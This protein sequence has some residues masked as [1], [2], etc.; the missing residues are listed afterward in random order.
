[1]FRPDDSL[2]VGDLIDFTIRPPS[3]TRFL[4]RK[5]LKI[6]KVFILAFA[7][8]INLFPLKKSFYN[9]TS[10]FKKDLARVVPTFHVAHE[11]NFS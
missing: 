8:D 9:V 10:F 3:L 6:L 1:M 5:I 4:H 11:R 7:K 2:E